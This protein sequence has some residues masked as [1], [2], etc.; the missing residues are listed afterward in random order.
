M[1]TL[2]Y[3]YDFKTPV[4]SVIDPHF[5]GIITGIVLQPGSH[6]YTVSY[7]KNG[8][9]AAAN[10][11]DFEIELDTPAGFLQTRSAGATKH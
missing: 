3:K 6:V 4:R 9:P 11:W 10:L 1:P 8:E 7:M 5:K 2:E